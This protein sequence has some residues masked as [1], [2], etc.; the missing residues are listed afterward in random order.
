MDRQIGSSGLEQDKWRAKELLGDQEFG[1][2]AK[3]GIL[4]HFGH[5][6]AHSKIKFKLWIWRCLECHSKL[7]L[8]P[9]GAT[10]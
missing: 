2:R 4:Y 6:D 10:Q 1:R 9:L 5:I 3:R 8:P 7:L